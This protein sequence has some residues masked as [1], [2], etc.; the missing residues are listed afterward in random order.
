MENKF[1]VGKHYIGFKY[2]D[3][4][5]VEI[6]EVNK[7]T[8]TFRYDAEVHTATISHYYDGHFSFRFNDYM[9]TSETFSIVPKKIQKKMTIEKLNELRDKMKAMV[10]DSCMDGTV[11]LWEVLNGQG[12]EEYVVLKDNTVITRQEDNEFAS[13][14]AFFPYRP[15]KGPKQVPLNTAINQV[16]GDIKK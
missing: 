14:I 15:Q 16:K 5:T 8:V 3:E 6:L 12:I 10:V 4:A 13:H 1:I 11:H 7:D 9:Y 2:K